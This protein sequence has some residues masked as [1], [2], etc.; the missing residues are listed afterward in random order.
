MVLIII[1]LHH[2]TPLTVLTQTTRYWVHGILWPV[3]KMFLMMEITVCP[4]SPLLPQIFRANSLGKPRKQISGYIKLK[5]IPVNSRSKKL[6]G[7][8]EQKERIAVV[9]IS[10]L[11][12]WGIAP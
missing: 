4:A 12:R 10:F 9:P 2:F 8:A 7:P 11:L 5:I 6:I 1:L 3:N